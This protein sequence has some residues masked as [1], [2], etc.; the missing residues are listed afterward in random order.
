MKLIFSL[1]LISTFI[2]VASAQQNNKL[3]DSIYILRELSNNSSFSKEDRI[4]YIKKAISLSKKT[5]QDTTVLKSKRQLAYTYL[6]TGE[7]DSFKKLSLENLETAKEL[8]DSTAIAFTN[9]LL[10]YYN[11]QIASDNNESYKY[12]LEA[13]KYFDA[14]GKLPEKASALITLAKIQD[15]EKD[16]L[17]SE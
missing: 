16:H 5:K 11:Y 15:E 13:L 12:Y 8:N 9:N 1:I 17:G 3:L 14:L 7:Y 4:D 6:L 10:G 2:N